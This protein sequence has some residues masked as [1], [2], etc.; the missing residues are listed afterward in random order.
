MEVFN[1]ENKGMNYFISIL[2]FAAIASLI[3]LFKCGNSDHFAL[4][5]TNETGKPQ[6]VKTDT[7]YKTIERPKWYALPPVEKWHTDSFVIEIPAKVD[8]LAIIRSYF[9]KYIYSDTTKD[10][11]IVIVNRFVVFEN[12]IDSAT[13]SYKL[14]REKLITNTVLLP[15]KS[16]LSLG[17]QVGLSKN[18]VMAGP[19]LLFTD[20]KRRSYGFGYDFLNK[21][22][23]AKIYF[24]IIGR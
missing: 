19:E 12:R 8:T 7:I 5:K 13:T 11:N 1:N 23:T 2:L 3:F 17:A 14:L 6:L 4:L 9:T 16:F 15:N 20:R 18:N 21:M 10:S 22:Y 24:K